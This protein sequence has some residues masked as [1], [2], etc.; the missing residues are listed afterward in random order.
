MAPP[1]PYPL[2]LVG[3]IS[4]SASPYEVK[5]MLAIAAGILS[6]IVVLGFYG[7]VFAHLYSEHRKMK[8]R[9]K[10]AADHLSRIGPRPQ[11]KPLRSPQPD[12]KKSQGSFR[13]EA[14]VNVGVALGGLAAMFAE[15]EILNRL[16]SASN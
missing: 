11:T 2:S 13:T 3:S 6:S 9:E 4:T 12:R 7:Y 8:A 10:Y 5:Y 1:L 15:I 16:L 14:L